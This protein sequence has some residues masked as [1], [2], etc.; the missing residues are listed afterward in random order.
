MTT[1][2]ESFIVVE[3]QR[4]STSCGIINNNYEIRFVN[5]MTG[6]KILNRI[7]D[8]NHY[9]IPSNSSV[10]IG[11]RSHINV[12]VRILSSELAIADFS[13]NGTSV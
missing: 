3:W 8:R 11:A 7:N 12:E 10:L 13:Y 4:P 6:Q 5:S 2:Y 9:I 1:C